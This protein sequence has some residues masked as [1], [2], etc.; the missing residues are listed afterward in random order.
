MSPGSKVR[1]FVFFRFE[2]SYLPFRYT[3]V[4][5]Q[6]LTKTVIETAIA[7]GGGIVE[8]L[9]HSY[10]MNDLRR[11]P[12]SDQNSSYPYDDEDTSDGR[13]LPRSW[14]EDP[15]YSRFEEL[16]DPVKA[17]AVRGPRKPQTGSLL[18][19][20][21]ES[22]QYDYPSVSKDVKRRRIC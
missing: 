18:A 7:G 1:K 9:R 12:N 6:K 14:H 2:L 5:A 13:V 22:D 15:R 19:L 21:S 8:T 10:S 16:D 11:V 17:R 3:K 20:T 4:A